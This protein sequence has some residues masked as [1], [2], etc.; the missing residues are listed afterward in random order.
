MRTLTESEHYFIAN[1]LKDAAT[2]Y[3]D[4]VDKF[5][6]GSMNDIPSLVRQLTDQAVR[7]ETLAMELE[8]SA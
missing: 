3:R 5:K 8:E 4:N 7:A 2:I 1:A 6:P